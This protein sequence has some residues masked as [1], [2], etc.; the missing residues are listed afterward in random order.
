M[1]LDAAKLDRARKLRGLLR[2]ELAEEAGL[3]LNAVDKACS[4]GIGGL[5]VARK[6]AQTLGLAV[7][8]VVI[9]PEPET[10]VC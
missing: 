6:L 4:V 5:V 2:R 7:S 8:E 1:R 10:Q 9:L 3:S